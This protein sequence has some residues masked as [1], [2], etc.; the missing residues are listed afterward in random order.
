MR[1]H[2]HSLN[3]RGWHPQTLTQNTISGGLIQQILVY[4][5]IFFI[6]YVTFWFYVETLTIAT[7]SFSCQPLQCVCHCLLWRI[8]NRRISFEHSFSS[9]QVCTYSIFFSLKFS[10]TF[11]LPTILHTHTPHTHTLSLTHTRFPVLSKRRNHKTHF[12]FT[13]SFCLE[14]LNET[15][16]LDPFQFM[17]F[18]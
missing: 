16:W 11:P 9:I 14:R 3:H 17:S 18:L 5:S 8:E 12:S 10:I 7:N 13:P 6:G 2:G 1:T 4:P 15:F